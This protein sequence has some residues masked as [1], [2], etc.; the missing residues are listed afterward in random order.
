MSNRPMETPQLLTPRD[1]LSSN[2]QAARASTAASRAP[3]P[4]A[5]IRAQPAA[6]D[7]LHRCTCNSLTR[8]VADTNSLTQLAD[9][10]QIRYGRLNKRYTSF[11]TIFY[12]MEA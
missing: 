1:C 11:L 7:L 3:T 6:V 12:K 8:E 2:H 9:N 4:P 5:I 10:M